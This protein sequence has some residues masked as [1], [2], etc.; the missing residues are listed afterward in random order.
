MTKISDG[1]LCDFALERRG[2][3]GYN[4]VTKVTTR[5]LLDVTMVTETIEE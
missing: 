5:L 3:I 4:M 1:S 2:G